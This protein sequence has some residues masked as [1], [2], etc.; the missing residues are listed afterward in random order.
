MTVSATFDRDADPQGPTDEE[1][2]HRRFMWL[3]IALAVFVLWLRPLTSSLWLDELGTWWVIKDGVRETISRSFDI[4]GQSPVFYLIAWV[5]RQ[6]VGAREWALRAPSLVFT[7]TSALLLYRLAR[8]MVD[9]EL[10]RIV[11]LIFV[12]WPTV[13]FAAVDFRP[14]ALATL[15]VIASTAALMRWLEDGTWQMGAVYVALAGATV[16]VHYV[17]GLVVLAH[18]AYVIVRRREAST[19]VTVRDL[20]FAGLALLVLAGPLGYHVLALWARRGEWS[21]GTPVTIG[22]VAW[23]ILAPA[24]ACAAALSGVLIVLRR[25]RVQRLEHLRGSDLVLLV[26]WA[27]LPI[28]A[29]ITVSLITSTSLIQDRY[30][31]VA[32]PAV[33]LLLGLAMRSLEPTSTRSIVAVA[34]AIVSVVGLGS[35]HQAG[36]WRGSLAAVRD[37]SSDET[38]VLLQPGFTESAQESWLHDPERRSFLLAPTSFYPVTG[39]VILLPALLPALLAEARDQIV[40]SSIGAD[41]VI[42]V[43][44]SPE[45]AIWVEEVLGVDRWNEEDVRT[46]DSPYVFEFDRMAT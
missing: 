27:T 36:D 15:L 29:L 8:R 10:G 44:N 28:G 33:A 31:L 4:Q 26:T 43:T 45:T 46:Q 14:Y 21:I 13:K 34:L 18:I 12:V 25:A 1:R 19:Q 24:V 2:F 40:S 16:Y 9:S 20:A 35:A 42:V 30:T 39:H 11:V 37:R 41:R 22:W 38:L 32:A 17:F 6:A 23:A 3:T 7:A 5:M